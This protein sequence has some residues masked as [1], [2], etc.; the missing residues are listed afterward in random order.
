VS[1]EGKL[2][3]PDI[4]FGGTDRDWE[5]FLRYLFIYLICRVSLMASG[6]EAEKGFLSVHLIN[7]EVLLM[8]SVMVV[9]WRFYN[10]RLRPGSVTGTRNFPCG[11][12]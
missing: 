8:G 7:F 9:I 11:P 4:S 1:E 5:R 12:R 6:Q 2:Q 3:A 10:S